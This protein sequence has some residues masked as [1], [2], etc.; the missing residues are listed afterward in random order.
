MD[1]AA[2]AAGAGATRKSLLRASW[3][4]WR[5]WAEAILR[6]AE[7]TRQSDARDSEPIDLLQSLGHVP[8][9]V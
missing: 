6:Q 4:N 9:I 1:L 3:I 2:T 8:G 7:P 5:T